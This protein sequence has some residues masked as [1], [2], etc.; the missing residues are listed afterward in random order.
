MRFE[1]MTPHA[2]ATLSELEFDEAMA[3]IERKLERGSEDERSKA[4][5]LERAVD[6]VV[7]RY[8]TY[9]LGFV[10]LEADCPYEHA[11]TAQWCGHT[12]CRW[13]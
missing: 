5:R 2:L 13:E 10:M 9:E 12:F 8:G 1:E 4:R 3:V 11:H 6:R 7:D